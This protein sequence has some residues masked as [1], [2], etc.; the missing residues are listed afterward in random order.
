MGPASKL[1]RLSVG[2]ADTSEAADLVFGG[3]SQTSK[4]SPA[5]KE[6]LSSSLEDLFQTFLV[7]ASRDGEVSQQTHFVCRFLQFVVRCGHERTDLVLQSMPS[8]LVS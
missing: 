5:L 2:V 3:A 4:P 6:S 8:T 1:L 7:V